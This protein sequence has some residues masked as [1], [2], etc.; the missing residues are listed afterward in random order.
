MEGGE[1]WK[2]AKRLT[3]VVLS[4]QPW[5]VERFINHSITPHLFTFRCQISHFSFHQCFWSNLLFFLLVNV[6]STYPWHQFHFG[7]MRSS[8]RRWWTQLSFMNDLMLSWRR[9]MRLGM[10]PFKLQRKV[11]KFP[12][13]AEMLLMKEESTKLFKH[14]ST[15]L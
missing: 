15:H 10:W 2:R 13:A 6:K 3:V 12:A 1:K 14:F 8:S 11:A 9:L 5:W 7:E 4:T